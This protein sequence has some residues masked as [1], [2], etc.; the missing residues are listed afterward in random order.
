MRRNTLLCAALTFSLATLARAQSDACAQATAIDPG[1]YVGSTSA[2][3][4]DGAAR[5]GSTSAAADVWYRFAAASTG[6][7]RL[8]TCG[9]DF[10]TVLSV[11]SGCPGT[12]ANEIA[13]SDDACGWSSALSIPVQAGASYA[14]RIAGFGAA[15]GAFVL[16]VTLAATGG[17]R[18][19]DLVVAELDVLQQFGR[20]GDVIGAAMASTLCNQGDAPVDYRANP[21]PRHP[22]VTWNFYRL[23]GDRF[24]QIGQSWVQHLVFPLQANQCGFGCAPVADNTAIGPGCS[25]VSSASA[26]AQQTGLG[27]RSEIDPWTGAFTFAGSHL[28]THAGGHSSIDHRLQLR[29]ADIDPA[30]NPGA[31]YF[32]ELRVVAHDDVYHLNDAAWEPVAISGSP[33]GTWVFSLAGAS[34]RVGPAVKAWPGARFTTIPENP[35]DDGRCV[36]AVKVTDIGGETW[37][38]EY[39]LQ[40]FD[41]SRGVG[42][43]SIPAG[44]DVA[45]MNAGFHAVASHGEGFSN[46]PW[47]FARTSD[48][49]TWATDPFETDPRANVLR[50]G[51][52]YNFWFDASAPPAESTAV[53]GLHRPGTPSTHLGATLGPGQDP[54]VAGSVSAGAGAVA[55]VL[56]VNGTAGA[57]GS[58]IVRASTTSV[59]E[60]SLGTAPSGPPSS[61]Y[62]LWAWSGPGS[63]AV[64]LLGRGQR[65]GCTSNPTPANPGLTPQPVRCLRGGV[66]VAACGSVAGVPAAPARASWVLRRGAG[67]LPRATFTLQGVIEDAASPAGFAVTNAIVLV[68][69]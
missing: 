57:S 36:L 8:D 5:C 62:V 25:D 41:L 40:N 30:Q 42:S 19:P 56:L 35:V 47:T 59:L 23:S 68:L 69:E 54:C 49:A 43:F 33:G 26:S 39:A 60:V 14:I 64:E 16:N 52:T 44:P 46:V 38:Y 20:S 17:A 13:C 50:W 12:P 10:D 37:H 28:A 1:T 3:T 6:T 11:H 27:P 53:L 9:S 18:G 31:S 61:R 7:L 24:E 58:R 2:A 21:D 22:F 15:G 63:R 48:R 67:T 51:T 55:D 45:I 66:P 32:A 29:D 34:S 4:T 65:I